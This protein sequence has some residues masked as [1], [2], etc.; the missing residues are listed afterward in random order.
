MCS[1]EQDMKKQLVAFVAAHFLVAAAVPTLAQTV[2]VSV[3]VAPEE[4]T[5]IKEYVVKEKVP[6]VTMKERISVGARVPADVEL[7]TR[8][9]SSCSCAQGAKLES[10]QWFGCC[11]G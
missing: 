11:A 5:R 8:S 2:G 3:N 9:T 10:K 6:T 1:L 4:R 7:R